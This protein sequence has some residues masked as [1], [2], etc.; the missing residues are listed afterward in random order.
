MRE[1]F[2]EHFSLGE[3][4]A[5]EWEA[6]CDGCAQCCLTR[7]VE[8]QQVTVY[9]IACE[10][11]DIENNRCQDYRNRL[12]RVPSCHKLTPNNVP[13]YNW[14]PETCAYRRI[15]E[16]RPLANWHPLIS[17][18]QET[19][20]QKGITVNHYAVPHGQVPKRRMAQHI[21]ATWRL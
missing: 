17:G 13:E 3:L 14:L 12:K 11:L 5:K 16:G 2:W 1:N 15:H 7:Y 18:S 8:N 21:I 4:N 10:L 9:N 19:M 20:R 6:L